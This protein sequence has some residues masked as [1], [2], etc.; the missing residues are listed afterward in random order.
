MNLEHPSTHIDENSLHDRILKKYSYWFVATTPYQYDYA[1]EEYILWPKE[2][3]S[4]LDNLIDE[5][6]LELIKIID[7]WHSIDYTLTLNS[8]SNMSYPQRLHFH[9]LKLKNFDSIKNIS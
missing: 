4:S 6:K 2:E 8:P 7:E 3:I 1:H 5:A 9:I